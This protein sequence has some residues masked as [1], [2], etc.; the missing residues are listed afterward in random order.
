MR[1]KWPISWDCVAAESK[2]GK[3]KLYDVERLE[4]V[5][6]RSGEKGVP[7]KS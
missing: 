3:C 1:Y 4:N 2:L 5:G 6:A 7:L